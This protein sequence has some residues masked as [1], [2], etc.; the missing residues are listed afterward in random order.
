MKPTRTT[1]DL[2]TNLGRKCN[3]RLY[4]NI[5]TQRY[6]NFRLQCYLCVW[7]APPPPRPSNTTMLMR[8]TRCNGAACRDLNPRV[9]FREH[10]D[11]A[12][13]S[14][15]YRVLRSQVYGALLYDYARLRLRQAK[16]ELRAAQTE[17]QTLKEDKVALGQALESKAKEVRA[18]VL[19]VRT[20]VAF[21]SLTLTPVAENARARASKTSLKIGEQ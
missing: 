6:F 4:V 21:M 1:S 10:F 9:L 11:L 20:V 7:N 18:Q 2:F 5:K 12:G 3:Q 13:S 19:Q 17:I 16:G 8:T 14:A 15:V